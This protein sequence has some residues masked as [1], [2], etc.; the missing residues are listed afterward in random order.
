MQEEY[1]KEL[2]SLEREIRKLK[3]ELSCAHS[4]TVSVRN[5]WFEIFEELQKEYERRLSA[6]QKEL[7]RMERCAIKAERQRD[8][9]LA[10]V[11]QQRHKIYELETA[12]EE[13]EGRNLKLRAQINRDYENSSIPS[14]QTIRHKKISNGREKSGRKPGAQPGPPGHGR[15]KQIP[16]TEPILLLPPQ[17]VSEDSDFKKLSKMIVKQLVN[18]RTILEVAEYHADVYYNS[19]TGE[20]IHAQFPPRRCGRGELRRKR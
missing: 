7:E 2:R 18:I 4:E 10:K 1:L 6:L 11:A 20:R 13:E 15:K 3:D 17:E 12:L 9:A 14:S 8:A 5:R 16:T 19:K